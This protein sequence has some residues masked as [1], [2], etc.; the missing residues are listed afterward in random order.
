MRNPT[1]W[2]NAGLAIVASGIATG[3]AVILI[4]DSVL[5]VNVKVALFCYALLAVIFGFM[6]TSWRHSEASTQIALLRGEGVIV[7]WRVDPAA[8]DRFA[9]L[10]DT[11]SVNEV[12][13]RRPAPAEGIEV[14]VGRHAILVDGYVHKLVW[15]ERSGFGSAGT[16]NWHVESATLLP[17]DPACVNLRIKM[18]TNRGV[19]V[20]SNLV[21]PIARDAESEAQRAIPWTN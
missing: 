7:H 4:P 16:G 13:V 3:A 6:W 14:V 19:P 17:G 11:F 9:T 5:G 15:P 1:L 8:W 2:R 21:F 12:K 20:Y 10:N 18:T